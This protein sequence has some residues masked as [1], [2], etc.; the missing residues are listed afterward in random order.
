MR[1]ET[2]LFTIGSW[3]ILQLPES[4][5]AKLPSRGQT[6]IE[7]SVNGVHFKTPLEPDGK[8]GHWF[9]PED[10][11]L[12]SANAAAGDTVTAEITPIKEWPEPKVPTDLQSA[13]AANQPASDLWQRITPMAR[14]EW[15]RWIRATNRSE[16]RTRRV[17]VACSKLASGERRPCC[18]N[19]NLCTEPQVS[20]NGV[21]LNPV[22]NK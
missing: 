21:L 16:T 10:S 4:A 9:R 17:E 15:I 20:K 18:W 13:L 14:W 11:L 6:M 19:R 2:I 8:W 12:K 22:A 7:G 1:F 3:T 5:S